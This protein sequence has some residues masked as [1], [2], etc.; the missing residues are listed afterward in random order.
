MARKH[1]LLVY[2]CCK[3]WFNMKQCIFWPPS[4]NIA[5]LR[6]TRNI[7]VRGREA[8]GVQCLVGQSGYLKNRDLLDLLVCREAQWSQWLIEICFINWFEFH[9]VK[10]G[11]LRDPTFLVHP[12]LV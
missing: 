1:W 6:K 9:A 2:P 12:P 7:C 4:E 3:T 8:Q 11:I 5:I 10:W